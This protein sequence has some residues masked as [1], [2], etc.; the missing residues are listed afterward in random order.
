[1]DIAAGPNLIRVD[2]VPGQILSNLKSANEFVNITSATRHRIHVLGIAK[3]YTHVGT[4][5]CRQSFLVVRNLNADAILG[6]TYNNSQVTQVLP[7][8]KCDVL[9]DGSVVKLQKRGATIPTAKQ[10]KES[11]QPTTP[12]LHKLRLNRRTLVEAN[13][14]C[15]I[16]VTVPISG[17]VLLRLYFLKEMSEMYSLEMRHC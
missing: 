4:H 1:M 9:K 11:L 16:A 10:T 14:E 15:L 8:K 13:S 17:T 3:L 2:F 5:C 7:R 6:T 12:C